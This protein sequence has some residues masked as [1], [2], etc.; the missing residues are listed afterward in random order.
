MAKPYNGVDFAGVMDAKVR[1]A[2]QKIDTFLTDLNRDLSAEQPGSTITTALGEPYIITTLPSPVL[3]AARRLAVASPLSAVDGG[4]LADFTLSL[5][6]SS[7][8][9]ADLSS[10]ASAGV[11]NGVARD[12]HVHQY[13]IALESRTTTPDD[14]LTLTSDG[15][16]ETLSLNRGRLKVALSGGGEVIAYDDAS[17]AVTV[18][19]TNR[20]GVYVRGRS[21]VFGN[22][23]FIGAQNASGSSTDQIF[24]DSD[25]NI[26]IL[27]SLTTATSVLDT[28]AHFTL[29]AGGTAGNAAIRIHRDSGADAILGLINSSSALVR[30]WNTFGTDEVTQIA[31]HWSSTVPDGASNSA[32][33][34]SDELGAG[35]RASGAYL[36]MEN[37]SA[38]SNKEFFGITAGVGG[39]PTMYV[40]R[41]GVASSSY[42]NSSSVGI[43]FGAK[44]GA[45]G[46]AIWQAYAASFGPLSSVAN[47]VFD[48]SSNSKG[49]MF[50]A[51]NSA[52]FRT[53]YILFDVDRTNNAN[54]GMFWFRKQYADHTSDYDL[55]TIEHV[56]ATVGGTRKLFAITVASVKGFYLDKNWDLWTRDSSAAFDVGLSYASSVTLTDN[57]TLTVDMGDDNRTVAMLSGQ[58]GGTGYSPDVRGIRETGTP[59]LLTFGAIT[60]GQFLKRVGATVVGSAAAGGDSISVN[61]VASTDAEF[62]DTTPAA[63]AG[64]V[65]VKWQQSGASPTSVSAYLLGSAVLDNT[66]RVTVRDNSGVDKGPRRRINFIEGANM[67]ISSVDDPGNEEVDVTFTASGG[68]G[69]DAVSVDSVAATDA[70]FDSA[71]PAAP[72]STPASNVAWQ[73]SG[74]SPSNI[75]A[76]ATIMTK[77]TEIDFGVTPVADAVFTVVDSNVTSTCTITGHVAYE[78]PTGKDLDEIEMDPLDLSFGPDGAG[79]FKLYARGMEGYVE[80][81]FVICYTLAKAS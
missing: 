55:F 28:P 56:P 19:D 30:Q 74:A 42:M 26:S 62:N 9:P 49:I 10:V 50:N 3:T 11:S 27:K 33:Y 16:T 6:L 66:A 61:T 12:D 75:S 79:Q 41:P 69:G 68:G 47:F 43:E 67:T 64:S 77:R 71:T 2:L 36:L 14:T 24:M 60:D 17:S 80:G 4:P 73:I 51:G 78:A 37:A 29:R 1:L 7:S 40:G 34:F 45:P 57:R 8:T 20:G 63:P 48:N 52:S 23:G 15:T 31:K 5:T 70:D 76:Y 38:A 25:G 32:F 53:P 54:D 22:L 18:L 59:T 46:T 39:Y 21:G 58:L 65:N 13:P 72:S 81:N 44:G 35:G